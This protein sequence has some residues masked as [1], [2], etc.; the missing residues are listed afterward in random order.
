MPQTKVLGFFQHYLFQFLVESL[1]QCIIITSAPCSKII[2]GLS[3][4]IFEIEFNEFFD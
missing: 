2:F 3:G 1:P 4:I